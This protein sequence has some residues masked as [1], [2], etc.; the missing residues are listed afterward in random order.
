MKEQIRILITDFDE[1]GDS[2]LGIPA[3]FHTEM[4]TANLSDWPGSNTCVE[5]DVP[6]TFGPAKFRRTP[7]RLSAAIKCGTLFGAQRALRLSCVRGCG[8]RVHP[9]DLDMLPRAQRRESHNSFYG[10]A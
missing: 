5:I 2:D 10:I 4:V 3:G 8:A 7:I 6:R 9:D 1:Q